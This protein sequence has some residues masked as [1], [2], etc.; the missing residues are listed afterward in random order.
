MNDVGGEITW[1]EIKLP[2]SGG[3]PESGASASDGTPGTGASP[4]KG[5]PSKKS[6]LLPEKKPL[7]EDSKDD[8]MLQSHASDLRRQNKKARITDTQ[9]AEQFEEDNDS[10]EEEPAVPTG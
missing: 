9:Q 10:E 2:V 1:R 8:M 4:S 7:I 3:E 5:T 6:L